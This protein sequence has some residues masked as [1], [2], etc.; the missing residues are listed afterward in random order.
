MK[1]ENQIFFT[2]ESLSPELKIDHM[3]VKCKTCRNGF[4][5]AIGNYVLRPYNK[6]KLTSICGMSKFSL[7]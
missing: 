6:V 5:T 7:L 1:L 2:W 4:K 3:K